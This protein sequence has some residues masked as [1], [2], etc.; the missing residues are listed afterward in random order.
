M[1]TT[2]GG[3][4]G[5]ESRMTVL[6]V[7][8]CLALVALSVGT[9]PTS[10]TSVVLLLVWLASG[11]WL[12]ERDWW[13]R[14]RHWLAPLLLFM[15]L[16]WF[17]LI[18]SVAPSPGLNPY[19]QRSHFWLL[20]LV[21]ASLTFTRL[22]PRHLAL[23]LIVGVECNVVLALAASLGLKLPFPKLYRFMETGY[24]SY[25]LL[26][27]LATVWL[28]FL[29][30]GQERSLGRWLI[31]SVV[32]LNILTISL[33]PGRGGY[34]AMLLLLP[35]VVA[36]L[37]QLR[38]WWLVVLLGGALAGGLGTSSAV[39]Q[40][41]SLA[42]HEMVQFAGAE[43]GARDTSIGTRLALWRG[44]WQ[45]FTERPV[46]GV[47]IDGYPAVMRHLYPDWRVPM[48]NPHN[49]YLYLAASYGLLGLTLFG[50]LLWALVR[51]A[52]PHR[53]SWP[54]FMVLTTLAVVLIGSL[55]ETTPLQP[56]TGILLAMMAGM[57][58][59]E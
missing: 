30:R 8:A 33:L 3:M 36:N 54:G 20:T 55:T 32:V 21:L 1:S 45:I 43:Q 59:S 5:S 29:A 27:V 41:I 22:Q 14:Q 50:W 23:A 49:Y 6:A 57:P 37:L 46:L 31:G 58:V 40:R 19:L 17:S 38:R 35:V 25:S 26:L 10:V 28:S 47:G 12:R 13:W 51:R 9:G 48:T 11:V 44:A 18:W 52:W 39:Q 4:A 7:L 42:G 53:A 34:L 56:Q 2:W 24:I 16:P 15:L